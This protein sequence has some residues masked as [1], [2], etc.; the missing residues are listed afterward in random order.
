MSTAPHRAGDGVG[1]PSARLAAWSAPIATAL[2]LLLM[3][4]AFSAP[5][6]LGPGVFGAGFA[7]VVQV[8]IES[9]GVALAWLLGAL[10][11][12]RIIRP[13]LARSSDPGASDGHAPSGGW[14][15]QLATGVAIMLFLS[16]AMGAV[17][18]L[19]SRFSVAFAWAPVL[20][21]VLALFSQIGRR[22]NRPELWGVAPATALFALPG[23]AMLIVGACCPPGTL[24]ASEARG[25]D[26]LSYHL[27]LPREWLEQ[28]RIAP[29]AHNVYSALPSYVE[30]A[31]A[32]L[33]AMFA[34]GAR[35]L[36]DDAGRAVFAAQ[37]LHAMLTILAAAAIGRLVFLL[38]AQ[39]GDSVDQ[40]RACL[41]AGGLGAS[42][43]LL[44]PW[45]IVVGSMTYNEMFIVLMLVGAMVAAREQGL[46]PLGR[47]LI[48]GLM[49][50]GAVAAKLTSAYMA[51]PTVV[52]VM[53]LWLPR[54]AWLVTMGAAAFAGVCYLAP[55]LIRNAIWLGNPVFPFAT[56]LFGSAHW[57]T[58]QV[59][60]WNSAHHSGSGWLERIGLLAGSERGALHSQWFVF[61]P[62]AIGAGILASLD[63]AA[64]SA[65]IALLGALALQVAGWV[66][67]G[68]QQS[69]FLL[70]AAP[71]G[72]ALVGIA[73]ANLLRNR[74]GDPAGRA[75]PRWRKAGLVILTAA[76]LA[77]AGASAMNFLSQNSA[78]PNIA[79]AQGVGLMNG[80]IAEAAAARASASERREL[81][82]SLAPP[83]LIN[84]AF[85]S[86]P[87]SANAPAL[88]VYLLGDATPFYLRAPA[89]YN[90]TWDAWPLA[91]SL[92][93]AD[94]D[95][96]RAIADLRSQGVTHILVNLDEVARLHS[97]GWADPLMTPE[98][99]ARVVREGGVVVWR[100]TIPERAGSF[101]V[102]ISGAQ[103]PDSMP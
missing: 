37:T 82:D 17:G 52:L 68:H 11:L 10:G 56:S 42:V 70:P 74:A 34:S 9:G 3:V 79:L 25:Y 61:F 55:Y 84:L 21:G 53:L 43:F 15:M 29:L 65:S 83:A 81:L 77:M 64:R 57:S 20:I 85:E 31:Y 54:R 41:R 23:A 46:R 4:F 67:F 69:R 19:G 95:F 94:G 35:A 91:E 101:L 50:G 33:G 47:G 51:L 88:R 28:A 59:A 96:D 44:T 71:I 48:I 89:L 16:H 7:A 72:A 80:A 100:W 87:R 39:P 66:C 98:L 8:W 22:E 78:Q 12:G 92:R 40:T 32:H 27:Q 103:S 38:A 62:V 75:A 2:A 90:T 18:L 30:A 73:A 5:G 6:S 26:T 60:R 14:T 63:R 99:A 36:T 1:A 58:E 76:L 86:R 24:W 49:M 97:D 13:L 93:R 45:V 102:D